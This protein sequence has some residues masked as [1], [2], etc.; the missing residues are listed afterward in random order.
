MRQVAAVEAGA[1]DG[2][3]AGDDEVGLV[4]RQQYLAAGGHLDRVAGLAAEDPADDRGGHVTPHGFADDEATN[5]F[6]GTGQ[7]GAREA[8][9]YAHEPSKPTGEAG[10]GEGPVDRGAKPFRH[11][12]IHR[13]VADRAATDKGVAGAVVDLGTAG[14]G[15]AFASGRQAVVEDVGGALGHHGHR[16]V[17][18]ALD[19]AGSGES[20]LALVDEDVRRAGG[21]AAGLRGEH[22]PYRFS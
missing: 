9:S 11:F 6:G 16:A 2:D 10:Q 7:R 21:D 19:G 4:L 13:E 20:G 15:I 8:A 12:V 22:L 1:D 3:R 14:D 18:L 17:L 5:E